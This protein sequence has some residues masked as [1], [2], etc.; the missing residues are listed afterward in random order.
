MAA[1][2]CTGMAQ[3]NHI[4]HHC[5]PESLNWPHV[6]STLYSSIRT[7]SKNNPQKILHSQRLELG[8]PLK[9]MEGF[10]PKQHEC[11]QEKV[12]LGHT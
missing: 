9:H 4:N 6:A 1:L 3:W 12:R 8:P 7:G 5:L 10:L 2:F 11:L